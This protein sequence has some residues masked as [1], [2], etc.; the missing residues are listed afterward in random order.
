MRALACCPCRCRL[1]QRYL[2]REVERWAAEISWLETIAKCSMPSTRAT[3]LWPTSK[4]PNKPCYGSSARD[5]RGWR[6]SSEGFSR[7]Y[8]KPSAEAVFGAF[9]PWFLI[10]A[11]HCRRDLHLHRPQCPCLSDDEREMLELVAHVQAGHADGA[12]HVAASLVHERALG[13]FL[14][15]SL[16]LAQAL[17]RLDL[18]L[19]QRK[20]AT[21]AAATVH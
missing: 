16:T 17:G 19:P 9:E 21:P 5:S 2:V 14:G 18:R 4:S 13:A 15:A 10:L 20:R 11:N 3:V 8:G 7:A 6:R 12:R 1:V